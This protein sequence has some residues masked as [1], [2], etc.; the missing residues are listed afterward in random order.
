MKKT[1]LIV[2]VSL[3]TFAANAFAQD[4]TRPAGQEKS[5]TTE[6]KKDN[7][8]SPK[9]DAKKEY[10]KASKKHHHKKGTRS[11]NKEDAAAEKK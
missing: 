9:P 4:A 8:D 6:V 10:G 2:L 3:I 11:A 1:S 7:Q 5:K